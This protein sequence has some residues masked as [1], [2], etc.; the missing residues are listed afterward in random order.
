VFWACS[1]PAIVDPIMDWYQNVPPAEV[2]DV[3]QTQAIVILSGG[4]VPN[5]REYD[6]EDQVNRH[7][8]VRVRYGAHLALATGVPVLVTGGD[9]PQDRAPVADKMADL[10][11]E[12]GVTVRWRE[13]RSMTTWDNAFLSAQQL[14]PLGKRRITLVTQAFHMRRSVLLFRAAGFEVLPAPTDFVESLDIESSGLSDL[15]QF[16]PNVNAFHDMTRVIHEV[17]GCFVSW[18]QLML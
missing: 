8:L 18:V 7:T 11:A 4:R 10:L 17:L 13:R 5:A 3:A 9:W 2:S 16:M 12:Y 15:L 14:L 1:A 6:G